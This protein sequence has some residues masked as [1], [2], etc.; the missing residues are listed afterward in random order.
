MAIFVDNLQYEE[1]KDNYHRS[2]VSGGV[3]NDVITGASL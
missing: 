2:S 3:I 1:M